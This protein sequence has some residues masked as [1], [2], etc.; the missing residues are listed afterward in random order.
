[1][2]EPSGTATRCVSD[3]VDRIA[4]HRQRLIAEDAQKDERTRRKEMRAARRT[5]RRFLRNVDRLTGRRVLDFAQHVVAT[6]AIDHAAGRILQYARPRA[7]RRAPMRRR[8]SRRCTGTRAGPSD[9]G[10]PEP[11][12]G[13]RRDP[14]VQRAAALEMA[15]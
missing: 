3:A 9:P 8:G 12:C 13:W 1:M 7:A 2:S 5:E 4:A 15:P 6:R 10:D 14:N 11:A